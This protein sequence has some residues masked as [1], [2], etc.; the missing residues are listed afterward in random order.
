[1]T[2][3]TFTVTFGRDAVWLPYLALS[4]EKFCSGFSRHVLVCDTDDVPVVARALGW[5]ADLF[6]WHPVNP[7]SPRHLWQEVLKIH[8]DRY[9]KADMLVHID[10]D[11]IFCRPATPENFMVDGKPYLLRRRYEDAGDAIMWRDG[12]ERAMRELVPY[13]YMC[14]LGQMYR[15]E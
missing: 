15:R 9:I 14:R 13:E 12:T 10:S 5:R 8:A 7:M 11:A 3:D 2:T 1:M 4:I 6:D